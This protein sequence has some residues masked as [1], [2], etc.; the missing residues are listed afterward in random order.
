MH[1]ARGNVGASLPRQSFA[2]K[3]GRYVLI[4]VSPV[5]QQCL[6]SAL[7]SCVARGRFHNISRSKL[8]ARS[9]L[10]RCAHH[11]FVRVAA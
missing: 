11:E 9:D 5:P 1:R 6:S 8:S 3:R 7:Q 10:V 4:S 2:D